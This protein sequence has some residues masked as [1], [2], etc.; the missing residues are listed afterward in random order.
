M[1]ISGLQSIEFN[2]KTLKSVIDKER[3]NF[4]EKIL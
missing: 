2:C 3:Q 4:Q 1:N